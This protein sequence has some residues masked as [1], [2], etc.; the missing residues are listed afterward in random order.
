MA[1]T[2]ELISIIVPIYKV[3]KYLEKC[4]QSIVRQTYANLEIIL[5]DDGSPDLCPEICDMWEKKDSRIKVIHKKNGGLSDARNAGL[6]IAKGEYIGFI[7]SDDYIECDMYE[8][9]YIALKAD[10]ADLA[11]CDYEKVTE[12]GEVLTEASPIKSELFSGKSGLEKL[13]ESGGVHYLMVWNKLYT[14]EILED[15]RFPVGKIHEDEFIIHKVFIKC[16]RIVSIDYKAYKYVQRSGSIISGTKGVKTLDLIDAWCQRFD[17]YKSNDVAQYCPK[18]LAA[19]VAMYTERRLLVP[20][21]C[22]FK[23]RKRI[24]EIDKMFKDIYL[25]NTKNLSLKARLK[26]TFPSIWFFA[27]KVKKKM[28]LR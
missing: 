5:V 20:E 10:N 15:I 27:Y 8:R 4:I 6:S 12:S 13:T 14:K 3:E 7:D 28:P 17:F 9:L 22:N 25:K 16:A 26:Y 23:E 19:I 1:V 21:I 18:L 24:F 11:I 2:G